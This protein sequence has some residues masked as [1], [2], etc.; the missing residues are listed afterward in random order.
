MDENLNHIGIFNSVIIGEVRGCMHVN[1]NLLTKECSLC[2]TFSRSG[3]TSRPAPFP[4]L[5]QS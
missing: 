5:C 4:N 3:L 2:L 1:M